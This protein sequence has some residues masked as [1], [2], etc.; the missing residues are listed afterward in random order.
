M[1]GKKRKATSDKVEPP[2]RRQSGRVTKAKIT[3]AESQASASDPPSD[4]EFKDNV[5][6][7]SEPVED[8]E[9]AQDEDEDEAEDGE[10]DEFEK[11]LKKKGWKK[12]KGKDGKWSMVIDLPTE[13]DDGGIPYTDEKIHPNTLQFLRDL[14]KNNKREWLKFHDKVFRLVTCGSFYYHLHSP[15]VLCLSSAENKRQVREIGS[16]S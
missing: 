1:A 14:K 7:A 12:K 3:Y 13:K 15:S 4:D 9:A 10:E 6:S 11:D 16:P 5:S 2:S 8:A